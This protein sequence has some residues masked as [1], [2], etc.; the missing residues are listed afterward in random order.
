MPFS[1][2][3]V[4]LGIAASFTVGISVY[5]EVYYGLLNIRHMITLR[6]QPWASMELKTQS[7]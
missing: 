6:P 4:F 7:R 3:I 5:N 1:V 2:I